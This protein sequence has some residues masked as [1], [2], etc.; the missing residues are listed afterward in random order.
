MSI[1]TATVIWQRGDAR[2]VDNRYSRA[3]EWL[4]KKWSMD[5]GLQSVRLPAATLDD[6]DEP[7]R[8][9]RAVTCSGPVDCRKRGIVES[10][11]D[12]LCQL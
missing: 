3:H 1:Y 2:F 7:S 11:E 12:T 8:P 10:Y 6:R 9:S 4:S 5:N